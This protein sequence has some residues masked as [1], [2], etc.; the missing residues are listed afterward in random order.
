MIRTLYN[1]KS[2]LKTKTEKLEKNTSLQTRK[3][4][5]L[6][7]SFSQYRIQPIRLT[8]QKINFFQFFGQYSKTFYT[9]FEYFTILQ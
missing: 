8:F 6:K 2:S 4:K 7:R 5:K 9:F 1:G 3:Q